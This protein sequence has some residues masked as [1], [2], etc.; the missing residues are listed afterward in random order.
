MA[1]E[2]IRITGIK[3][4]QRLIAQGNRQV[5]QATR[6]AVQDVTADIAQKAN[7]LVPYEEGELSDSQVVTFPVGGAKIEGTVSYGG[8]A[9]PYAAIQHENPDYWHPAKNRGGTGPVEAGQ[10]SGRGS[11]YLEYPTTQAFIGYDKKIVKM[12]K[13]LIK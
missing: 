13:G 6:M 12:I 2:P 5:I 3:D 11:K 8:T 7:D 4:V 10:G 9:A 1:K